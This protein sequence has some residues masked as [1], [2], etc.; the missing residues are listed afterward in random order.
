MAGQTLINDLM[1]DTGAGFSASN[2][3]SA[4]Q[5][6]KLAQ[7]ADSM[8]RVGLFM[9]IFGDV[10][11]IAIDIAYIAQYGVGGN[12]ELIAVTMSLSVMHLLRALSEW[13]FQY[14]NKKHIPSFKEVTANNVLDVAVDKAIAVHHYCAV[15][16]HGCSL[17]RAQVLDVASFWIR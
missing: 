4:Q 11:G 9:A 5:G 7:D 3:T 6:K 16:F 2:S 8:M 13:W 10:P 15:Q 17:H 14:N 1:E 12:P